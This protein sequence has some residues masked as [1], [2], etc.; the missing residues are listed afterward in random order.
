MAVEMG[1]NTY[2][3]EPPAHE[4]E[5]QMRERR[6]RER[7]YLVLF[8]HDRSL[9]M[10]T[11]RQWMLPLVSLEACARTLSSRL[12]TGRSR[13]TVDELARAGREYNSPGGC[14]RS[15]F[16]AASSDRC[17]YQHIHPSLSLRKMQS[18]TTDAF[19]AVTFNHHEV[20]YEVLRDCNAQLT[21]WMDNWQHEMR[22]GRYPV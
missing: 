14:H 6:N 17:M 19:K 2:F 10:Q 11:G 18:D 15:R 3:A 1:L 20:N 5:F 12:S 8:V 22:R 16:R 21:Q 7:T 13:K 4:T 9:S